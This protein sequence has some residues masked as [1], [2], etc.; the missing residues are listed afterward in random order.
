M[1][2]VRSPGSRCL[3]IFRID[4][5]FRID[6]IKLGGGLVGALVCCGLIAFYLH[7]LG[8][9]GGVVL[10]LDNLP[11]VCVFV[12][13]LCRFLLCGAWCVCG[14]FGGLPC[15]AFILHSAGLLGIGWV[16]G[17]PWAFPC[18]WLHFSTFKG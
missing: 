16:F 2:G 17:R 4:S 3:G 5:I 14:W 11:A 8:C 6:I 15:S 1:P 12:A 9:F 13:Y 18:F 10:C 7:F